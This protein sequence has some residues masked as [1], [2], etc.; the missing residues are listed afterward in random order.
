MSVQ[1]KF[2]DTNILLYAHDPSEP[3][4]HTK[5]KALLERLWRERTG[6]LSVPVLQEFFVNATRKLSIPLEVATAR[7]V[8]EDYSQ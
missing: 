1:L 4:K 2:V 7:A 3:D 6:C 8:I 5:A